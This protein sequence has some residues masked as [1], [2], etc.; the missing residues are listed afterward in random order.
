MSIAV[1]TARADDVPSLVRLR[2]ANA[3]AHIEFDPATY[4][5]P[6]AEAVRRHFE[7]V[8]STDGDVLILVAEVD[9]EVAGMVEVVP[10]PDPPDHQIA[11]PRA[12][13]EVHTVV[14]DGYRNRGVGRALL[15]EAER[16]AAHRG[17]VVISAGIL[18]LN[19]GAVR[20]YTSAGFGARG[21]WLRKEISA[22]RPS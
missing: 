21:T 17:A 22:A 1:R 11:V 12:S 9:G 8:V 6:D 13:A 19:Q 10:V 3:Q 16:V 2:Q 15:E 5:M 20:F 14:L 18:T 7:H 4:R